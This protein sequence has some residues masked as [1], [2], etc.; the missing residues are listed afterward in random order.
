MD[1]MLQNLLQNCITRENFVDETSSWV[2]Y[3]V[4]LRW[5]IKDY[6]EHQLYSWIIQYPLASFNQLMRW[7]Q[8]L[9][10]PKKALENAAR[11]KL[12]YFTVSSFMSTLL[13][14]KGRDWTHSFLK[15]IYRRF[16][17]TN[18]PK[19]LGM[20]SILKGDR[21]W[22]QLKETLG[23]REDVDQLVSLVPKKKRRDMRKRLQQIVFWLV[24]RQKA[25][26][27]PRTVFQNFCSDEELAI[28][29]TI[30][31]PTI[32]Y[33]PDNTIRNSLTSIFHREVAVD[34]THK[35][36]PDFVSPFGT[37]VLRC[38][39]AGCGVL[40][41][42]PLD[43]STLD[44]FAVR[45]RRAEHLNEVFG[46]IQGSETGLPEVV[47]APNPPMS[48][49]YNLHSGVA[50]TWSHLNR[51]TL[52]KETQYQLKKDIMRGKTKAVN[53]FVT[54]VREHICATSRRGNIYQ[55][56]LEEDI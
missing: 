51:N 31:D 5:T 55:N 26:A 22:T 9:Q 56:G 15:L 6:E 53:K 4:T 23:A 50:R 49:H 32:K 39:E 18:V 46:V 16:N 44:P 7:Y 33:I 48:A 29:H 38:T 28:A 8:V 41:Y 14:N 40:F 10:L 20:K 30:L 24:Y 3:P 21:F 27:T 37:S 34:E 52:D 25:H 36:I 42:D 11:S 1:W 45:E 35:G 2:K 19:D 17:T 54:D 43:P 47:Q 12:I 13:N